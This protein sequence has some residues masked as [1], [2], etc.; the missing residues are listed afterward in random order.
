MNSVEAFRL[1]HHPM[2]DWFMDEVTANRV[3]LHNDDGRLRGGPDEARIMPGTT[4][5]YIARRGDYIVRGE[6][7]LYAVRPWNFEG[8]EPREGD[9]G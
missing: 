5:Q 8:R 7:G 1:G 4:W 9:L 2:P 3:T 6:R